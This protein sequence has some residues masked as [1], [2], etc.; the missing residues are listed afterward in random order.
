MNHIFEPLRDKPRAVILLWAKRRVMKLIYV[1]IIGFQKRKACFELSPKPLNLSAHGFSGYDYI[2][3][4]VRERLTYFL[5]TV[6]VKSCSIK[7]VDAALISASQYTD[8]LVFCD[9][10]YR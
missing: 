1:N 7:I 6:S 2:F 8:S 10:L 9:T 5:L 4:H 3:S